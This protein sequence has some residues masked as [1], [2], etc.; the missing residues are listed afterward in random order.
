MFVTARPPHSVRVLVRPLGIGGAAVCCNGA[1]VYD[2]DREAALARAP[3]P[4]GRRAV[5]R[6][7]GDVLRRIH[8]T[9]VPPALR[10]GAE[11]WLDRALREAGA[12]LAAG[13]AAP[14]G[15]A[16]LLERLRR[17]RPPPGPPTLIH[18]DFTIDNVLVA[19][20]RVAGAI[21]WAGAAGRPPLRPRPGHAAQAGGVP[22][23]GRPRGVLRRLRGGGPGRG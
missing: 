20:G 4:A 7:F 14:A 9:A 3:D 23:A 10:A 2:L 6:A 1:L 19:G 11:P 13:R 12:N 17:R 22:G 5:L 18:G 8:T 21:D 15:T 16:E